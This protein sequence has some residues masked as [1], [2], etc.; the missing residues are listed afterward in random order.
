MTHLEQAIHKSFCIFFLQ[1]NVGGAVWKK[2]GESLTRSGVRHKWERKPQMMFKYHCVPLL[3]KDNNR[4]KNSLGSMMLVYLKKFTTCCVMVC[5]FHLT[6]KNL[7][8]IVLWHFLKY[9]LRK[10]RIVLTHVLKE[11][12]LEKHLLLHE[13]CGMLLLTLLLAGFKRP[14]LAAQVERRVVP[15]MWRGQKEKKT[16]SFPN[17]WTSYCFNLFNQLKSLATSFG[18]QVPFFVSEGNCAELQRPCRPFFFPVL[19]FWGGGGGRGI[20]AIVQHNINNL[21]RF[22]KK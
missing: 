17:R 15:A 9:T 22:V 2:Q 3:D 20:T 1:D 18:L 13:C 16:L 7:L 4:K 21:K 5:Q 19:F 10:L 8:I 14:L 6:S 12:L 11:C